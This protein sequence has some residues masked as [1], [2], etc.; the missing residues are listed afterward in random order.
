MFVNRSVSKA[1]SAANSEGS[2]FNRAGVDVAPV[3]GILTT[4]NEELVWTVEMTE[5]G[6][7]LKRTDGKKLSIGN[8]P[9]GYGLIE[10]V[11]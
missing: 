8:K 6:F 2:T 11:Q 7:F 5:G 10:D 1:M 9:D 3:N 4:D